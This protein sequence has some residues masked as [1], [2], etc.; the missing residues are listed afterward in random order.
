MRVRFSP[1]AIQDID[2]IV[3]PIAEDDV[4]VA[5]EFGSTLYDRAKEIGLSSHAYPECANM[6][7]GL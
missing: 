2:E 5:F 7:P 6:R 4:D 1:R 3:E